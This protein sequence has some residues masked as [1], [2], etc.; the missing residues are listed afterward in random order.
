MNELITKFIATNNIK[1][2]G[3]YAIETSTKITI[4]KYLDPWG[5]CFSKNFHKSCHLTYTTIT[6][7]HSDYIDEVKNERINQI[8]E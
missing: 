2:Y 4:G 8:L 5:K 6:L 3:L 1:Y 7:D